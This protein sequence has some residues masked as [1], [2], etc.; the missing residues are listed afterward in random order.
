MTLNPA[1]RKA[2]QSLTVFQIGIDTATHA[3][4][5]TE[6]FIS[7]TR[8]ALVDTI[9]SVQDSEGGVICISEVCEILT[10]LKDILDNAM[11]KWVCNTAGTLAHNINSA[12]RQH[13]EV[14]L[15]NSP[16]SQ[17]GGHCSC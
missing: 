17:S 9:Y 5:S 13:Y 4:L 15:H 6:K 8:V 1:K 2:D 10:K 3:P 7:D 14:G 16:S 11:S 12:S